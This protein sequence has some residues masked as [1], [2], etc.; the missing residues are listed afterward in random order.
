MDNLAHTLIGAALGRAVGDRQIRHAALIG[1]VA[2][3]VP[4]GAEVFTGFFSW[5]RADYLLYH[6]GITHSLVVAVLE[7][8][9]LT[10]LIGLLGGK[11]VW[12]EDGPAW[13]MLTAVVTVTLLSHLFLDWQGSYGWRP[14]LPWSGRWYYLDWVAIADPFFW[15]LPLIALAWGAERHWAPLLAAVTVG[16]AITCIIV[17]YVLAGGWVASWVLMLYGA[18][19]VAAAVGWVRYW[20]G[21]IGR[22]RAATLAVLVLAAYTGAQGIVVQFRKAKIRATAQT[23]FGADAEWAALTNIGG[24]FTWEPIY[25]N[26]DTVASD[27]WLLPRHL[28]NPLVMRALREKP[29]GRA[30][31]RFARFLTAEAESTTVYLWDARY[32]R[33]VRSGWALV[34]VR[35]D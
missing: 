16:V 20:F 27:D 31:A 7:I 32:A 26:R 4:D 18:L 28:D 14:F 34:S 1:T 29:E 15:L 8:L 6:R 12:R 19:V 11:R 9:V 10:L 21:P 5:T 17:R 22:Q 25:A 35:M 23:R 30:M 2:G 3:N 13:G 33:A 24:P